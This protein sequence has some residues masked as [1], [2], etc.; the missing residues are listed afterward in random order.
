M[1]NAPKDDCR[2]L[3]RAGHSIAYATFRVLESLLRL[4][5]L[6]LVFFIGQVIG[7]L[8]YGFLGAYRRLATRNLTIA[9]GRERSPREIRGMVQRSFCRLGG[10][11]FTSLI[12]PRIGRDRIRA[13]VEVVIAEGL[14]EARD[15]SRGIIFCIPHMGAWE[16]LS[17]VP[18]LFT[19]KLPSA[20][21]YQTLRNPFFDAYVR[22][23]R[24][25]TGLQLFDR[26]SGFRGPMKHLRAAGGLGILFDQHAGDQGVWSPLFGRLASTTPLPAILAERTDSVLVLLHVETVGRA[27]WRLVCGS[28]L[29]PDAEPETTA[30][31]M[32]ARLAKAIVQSP[33]DWFWVHDRWKTPKPDFLL[34]RYRRGVALP[35]Q[36][37]PRDLQPF[38][39]LVRS[40]NWLGD[41]CMS[42]PAVRAIQAGRPDARL[43]VL[44]PARFAPV[45]RMMKQVAEVIEKPDKAGPRVVGRLLRDAGRRFDVAI[46]LPNSLRSALEAKAAGVPRIVGYAG[47]NRARLIDQIVPEPKPGRPPEHQTRQLMGLAHFLGADVGAEVGA[48]GDKQHLIAEHRPE[49]GSLRVGICPGAAYGEAKRLP[50]AKFA[51]TM[52]QVD[53]EIP[54]IEWVVVGTAQEV[55]V[56]AALEEQATGRIENLAGKTDLEGL[57]QTLSGLR[58]LFTNDTGTMHLAAALGV[59]TIAVFGSTEPALTGPLGRGHVVVRNHVECS[60][61]FL[62]ECPLDF[63]C[64]ESI[65]P[66][67]LAGAVLE[68][69][70]RE[71]PEE[72]AAAGSSSGAE[73]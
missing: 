73:A 11:L 25:T 39:I 59:P 70:R 55:G 47:H 9:F 45:W 13:R 60:P 22:R 19:G 24:A 34:A 18:E 16:L 53:G 1:P 14:E 48:L 28:P 8:C 46:L 33:E 38:E 65:S 71:A 35:D 17:Q 15:G 27:R 57:I 12:L 40:P 72:V 26:R 67:S 61:C 52:N 30:A 7:L 58:A 44:S 66:A 21:M 29:V 6:P 54:G 68:V 49:A 20:T 5:P 2:P 63:R 31:E 42:I 69:L 64:M 10:N 23:R 4:L 62:R 36:T 43:T 41:I 32:N 56:A 3:R 50:T 51:Q 37:A